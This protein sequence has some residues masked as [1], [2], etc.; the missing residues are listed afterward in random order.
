MQASV[1]VIVPCYNAAMYLRETLQSAIDQDSDDLEII[2]IDDGSTDGTGD[3]IKRNFPSVRLLTTTNGGPSSARNV[4][5][6]AATGRFI[7]YLDSDDL[8]AVGKLRRQVQALESEQGDV[9][10]GDWQTVIEANGQFSKGEVVAKRMRNPPDVDL[11]TGF[12]CPPAAYLIRREIVDRVGGWNESLPLIEDVR[13]A[14]DCAL[15]GAKFIYTPGVAALHRE[16]S[17]SLS[18]SDP[19]K[20]NQC[21]YKNMKYMEKSWRDR[22]NLIGTRFDTLVNCYA[23]IARGCFV[24]DRATSDAAF[25]DLQ[26]LSPQFVPDFSPQWR[27]L[28]ALIGYRNA[29]RASHLRKSLFGRGASAR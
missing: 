29:V 22:G 5:T 17:G 1:S 27:V 8:L 14:L 10:Y 28:S 16:H 23:G 26:R 6:K 15:S 21:V 12:W 2:A 18:Q 7:Q 11:L 20:F 9:A 13:F 19:V 24:N 3:L 4:G 25:A